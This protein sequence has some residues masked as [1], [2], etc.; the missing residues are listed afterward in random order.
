M[1]SETV[2]QQEFLY[3]I[4]ASLILLI[5]YSVAYIA[6]NRYAQKH[7][8]KSNELLIYLQRL[9]GVISFGVV[10]VIVVQQVLDTD[11]RDY[12]YLLSKPYSS[13]IWLGIL[14]AIVIPLNLVQ[15]KKDTNLAAYPQIRA[16]EWNIRVFSLSALSWTAYLLAYEFFFRGFLFYAALRFTGLYWAIGIN[17]VLYALAHVPKGRFETIG[18]IPLGILLC[19]VTYFTG[20]FWVAFG[21]HV[22]MA[23]SNEWTSLFYHRKLKEKPQ[24]L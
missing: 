1:K 7:S 5:V 11:I 24:T 8:D 10:P 13:L 9:T 22:V 14:S 4:L 23:L 2:N 21:V 19:I 6:I 20:S 16:S 12:G 18:A 3:V 15:A 17:V